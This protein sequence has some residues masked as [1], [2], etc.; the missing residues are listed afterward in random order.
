MNVACITGRLTKDPELNKTG[1][2]NAVLSF[3][4][5][6]DRSYQKTGEERKTDFI[7]CVAWRQTAEFIAR[8]FSKGQMIAVNGELQT[9]EYED[10]NGVKRIATEI[11]VNNVSFC[12]DKK[13]QK[14]Q[15]ENVQETFESYTT[16]AEDDYLPF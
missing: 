1:N 16:E 4:V 8:N 14:K 15:E 5:A 9:R 11:M 13:K 2:G 7:A 6:V 3:Y 10:R 12:G